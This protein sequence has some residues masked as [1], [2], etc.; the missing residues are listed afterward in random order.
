MQTQR[1]TC[2]LGSAAEYVRLAPVAA[3]L[4]RRLPHVRQVLV[5]TDDTD[6]PV[7]LFE[8]ELDVPE[9]SYVLELGQAGNPGHLAYALDRLERVIELEPPEFALVA[10]HG[11]TALAAMLAAVTQAVPVAH[12]DAGFRDVERTNTTLLTE[13]VADEVAALHFA[14]S[15]EAM[16]R[17]LA[18]G[19]AAERIHLVGSTM[20]DALV[21]LEDR[22]GQTNAVRRHG[23]REDDYLLVALRGSTL[24]DRRTLWEV[25][26]R[27]G[28]LSRELPVA[29]AM[30]LKL[31][32]LIRSY[33]LC[34]T[35][36]Q[37]GPLD[38]ADCL[39]LVAGA[40]AVLT[41]SVEVQEEATHFRVRCLT[42]GESIPVDRSSLAAR[43]PDTRPALWD[44][45]ASERVVDVLQRALESR[46]GKPDAS[47]RSRSVSDRQPSDPYVGRSLLG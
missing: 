31:Q 9:L 20:I 30:N 2:V 10:G 32:R 46:A 12:L 45:R 1:I 35:I 28:V 47:S 41:D 42:L 34:S 24:A 8:E 29:L 40:A 43:G 21:G 44:G 16:K 6:S 22:L 5:G 38:Y 39:D 7:S 37:L 26:E 13:R 18:Q 3:T 36:R 17:L 14:P 11:E 23:L 15:E 19:V 27:L 4:R 25:L 33:P